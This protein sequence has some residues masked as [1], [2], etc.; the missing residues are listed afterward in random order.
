MCFYCK[1]WHD[2]PLVLGLFLG[3]ISS[4]RQRW[5]KPCTTISSANFKLVKL[6]PPPHKSIKVEIE[7]GENDEEWDKLGSYGGSWKHPPVLEESMLLPS[8]LLHPCWE[9]WP[10]TWAMINADIGVSYALKTRG[11]HP[12]WH[13]SMSRFLHEQTN[14]GT[15]IENVSVNL[16]STQCHQVSWHSSW[17]ASLAHAL[18]SFTH[19]LRTFT[20][21]VI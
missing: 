17:V 18:R 15:S 4:N 5:E 9:N 20:S 3:F 6:Q 16:Y 2:I 1:L 14:W 19:P 13:N 21:I 8:S 7:Q 12:Q 11:D 10:C